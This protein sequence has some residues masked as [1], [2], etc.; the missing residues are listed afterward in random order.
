MVIE[1]YEKYTARSYTN[2]SQNALN[3]FD[4]PT[5]RVISYEYLYLCDY[6]FMF[7]CYFLLKSTKK[8]DYRM[9]LYKS[10]HNITV[11][12]KILRSLGVV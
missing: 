5:A 3:K 9:K 10:T 1:K 4:T 7:N 6:K 2:Y 11:F 12:E 8:I